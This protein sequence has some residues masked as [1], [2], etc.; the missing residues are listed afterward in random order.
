MILSFHPCID[1]DVNIIVAG[2]GP[3]PEEKRLVKQ[4]NAIILPQGVRQDLYDLCRSHCRI[5]FPNY[6]FRF[7]QAGKIGDILLFRE[8]SVPHPKTFVFP[9]AD[10][11]RRNFPAR[12]RKPFP[13]PFPFVLKGNHSGEGNLVFR[14]QDYEHLNQRLEQLAA[15]E[16]SG[17]HG[18]IA[19]QWIDHGGRDVRFVVLNDEAIGYWRVQKDPEQFLTNLSAGGVIDDRSDPRLLKKAKEAV[20][21]FCAQ[22]GIN[23]AGIDL[24]FDKKDKTRQPLFVEI[25]YWFGRRFFGSSEN[26]YSVLKR[27]VQRWLA[28]FDPDWPQRIR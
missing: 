6:D 20:R 27:A 9:S 22:T 16:N 28:G 17:Q 18:F 12:R 21:R 4:A 19:Q 7:A 5:V 26:Y 10:Y 23:L 2:R 25:N 11:Y 13:L 15:M 1:A 3:G 14:I 24:M 8:Y